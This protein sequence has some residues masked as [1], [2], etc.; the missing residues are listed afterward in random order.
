MTIAPRLPRDLTPS[1][2]S[3]FDETVEIKDL[4]SKSSVLG[5][6]RLQSVELWPG[7]QMMRAHLRGQAAYDAT[8]RGHDGLVVELRLDGQSISKEVGGTRAANLGPGQYEVAACPTPTM[9][10]VTAPAQEQFRTVALACK[11]PFL[12]ALG[13]VDADL[14]KRCD[15]A[16]Q[17]AGIQ[18][19][20]ASQ[21]A[22]CLAQ[23]LLDLDLDRPNARLAA[24][25]HAMEFLA[26][27]L[28]MP[29]PTA[30]TD[31]QMSFVTDFIRQNPGADITISTI[32]KAARMSP[33]TLK[34][35]FRQSNGYSIGYAIRA[36]RM[37][38]AREMLEAG[39]GLKDVADCL[40]Y[41]S[42]DALARALRNA[43][44]SEM[45]E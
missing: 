18:I 41:S 6:G 19:A 9:W 37:G 31:D 35:R 28:P 22:I 39:S 36:E 2:V 40:R 26:E 1:S 32:A 38:L 45:S 20:D 23:K 34:A 25:G 11:K 3:D 5:I 16:L 24:A 15:A 14:A 42:A 7:L 43:S 33:S 30:P 29:V 17:E 13:H 12:D 4:T 10:H 21:H 8:I 27:T 44:M